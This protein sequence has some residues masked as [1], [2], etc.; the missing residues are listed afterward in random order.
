MDN[1]LSLGISSLYLILKSIVFL[2]FVEIFVIRLG[3]WAY[4]YWY[5]RRQGVP[6]VNPQYPILGNYIG[7]SYF[8]RND[9]IYNHVPFQPLVQQTFDK[10][11]KPPSVLGVMMQSQAILILNSPE[12]LNDMYLTKNKYF[13]KHP[14]AR[15]MFKDFFGESLVFIDGGEVWQKRRKTMSAA[16]YKDKLVK[17]TEVVREVVN[18][19]I[20]EMESDYIGT[21]KLMNVAREMG[22]M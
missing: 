11:G 15:F 10:N 13:E 14:V 1:V 17:M 18:I 12:P 21:G 20:Q 16:F 5:Y 9:A 2:L 6:F 19:K 8:L 7:F 22:D 4:N 3:M